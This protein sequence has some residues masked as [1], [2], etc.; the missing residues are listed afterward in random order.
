M[1][2]EITKIK[3]E[4]NR[5]YKLFQKSFLLYG[6]DDNFL[7]NDYIKLIDNNNLLTNI[8]LK[9]KEGKTKNNP[10]LDYTALMNKN[11]HHEDITNLN[12]KL[13]NILSEMELNSNKTNNHRVLEFDSE[14]SLLYIKN[15]KIKISKQ[16]DNENNNQHL[17]MEYIFEQSLGDK[18]Y[19]DNI[20][21][22]VFGDSENDIKYTR[23]TS[24]CRDIQDKIM[25]HTS[26]KIDNFLIFNNSKKGF[27]KIN[28][29]YLSTF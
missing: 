17:I 29:K 3:G 14:N 10:Y 19:Y 16:Q 27:V 12:I 11:R 22:D 21:S 18:V 9:S 7:I 23:C 28:N 5:L 26:G 25:K 6:M 1:E 2:N 20:L 4:L 13:I 15:D 8:L 24:A